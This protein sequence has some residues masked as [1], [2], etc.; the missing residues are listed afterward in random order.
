MGSSPQ[1]PCRHSQI[2]CLR[3][4]SRACDGAT[5][6]FSGSTSLTIVR[7]VAKR[8]RTGSHLGCPTRSRCGN[9]KRGNLAVTLEQTR[10]R[11]CLSN[12]LTSLFFCRRISTTAPGRESPQVRLASRVSFQAARTPSSKTTWPRLSKRHVEAGYPRPLVASACW[13]IAVGLS[14][15]S[16]RGHQ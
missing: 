13:P 4:A 16:L 10:H 14:W 7:A 8:Y 11:T 2:S 15:T 5:R 12:P 9:R 6:P 3:P 1:R